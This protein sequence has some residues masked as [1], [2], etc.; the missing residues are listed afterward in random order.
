V[1]VE[2]AGTVDVEVSSAVGGTV[3]S[4][5]GAVVVGVVE[6]GDV[7]T[8]VVGI[9]V[10]GLKVI[11]G[12]TFCGVTG[13]DWVVTAVVGARVTCTVFSEEGAPA[14]RSEPGPDGRTRLSLPWSAR[15]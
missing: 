13:V 1:G 3:V 10:V 5:V 14:G 2:V 6:V 7:A 4:G 8:T 11:S 15:A 9:A 12:V